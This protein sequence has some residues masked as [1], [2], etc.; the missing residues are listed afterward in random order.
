M[1]NANHP[2]LG[3]NEID[4]KSIS[5]KNAKVE[6][7][8]LPSQP[9]HL[10]NKTLH[11]KLR[12]LHV[13]KEIGILPSDLAMTNKYVK[14]SFTDRHGKFH[15]NYSI[16]ISF[17]YGNEMYFIKTTG[18]G[19][20][21]SVNIANNQ[22]E[23]FDNIELISGICLYGKEKFLL[24]TKQGN[25]LSL[26][27]PNLEIQ[28][29]I[30]DI[31]VDNS[32][33]IYEIDAIIGLSSFINSLEQENENVKM[34]HVEIPKGQYYLFLARAY[35]KGYLPPELFQKCIA[36]ID[37]R[38]NA[39]FR[40]YKKRL[41][42]ENICKAEPLAPVETY[43]LEALE[44]KSDISFE[45]ACQ[46]LS[47]DEIWKQVLTIQPPHKW[48]EL[49]YLSH[50]VTFLKI[51]RKAPN[52]AVL[53]IDDPIEEKIHMKASRIIKK[54]GAYDD[55]R[56]WGIYPLQKVFFRPEC[57]SDSDLYYSPNIKL[58]ISMIKKI[59]DQSRK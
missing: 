33:S 2:I 38:H 18:K 32:F 48:A 45:K 43:F 49:G 13:F 44:K 51:G 6:I 9:S 57:H 7:E 4:E 54:L 46:I 36:E 23:R 47:Q 11:K 34:I 35:E 58:S 22:E 5:I 21:T 8:S 12:E 31:W 53:Q 16:G 50:V 27:Q 20:G 42:V 28:E 41:K 24:E 10:K 15:H 26:T 40:A 59:I 56:V 1:M 39:V 3:I 52:K 29:M 30:D 55:Y 37:K 17:P 19:C 25:R 14:C